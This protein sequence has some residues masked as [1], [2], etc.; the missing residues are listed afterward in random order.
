MRVQEELEPGDYVVWYQWNSDPSEYDSNA[1]FR[2]YGDIEAE[3]EEVNEIPGFN[4]LE[5][6]LMDVLV[7]T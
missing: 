4:F 7:D 3:I 2:T 1:T 6:C 5:L